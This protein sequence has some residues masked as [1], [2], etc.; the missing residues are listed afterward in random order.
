MRRV[1]AHVR[2][3]RAEGFSPAEFKAIC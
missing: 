3:V 2:R 1:V